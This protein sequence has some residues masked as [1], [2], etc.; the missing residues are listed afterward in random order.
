MGFKDAVIN[1][2][3]KHYTVSKHY[4]IHTVKRNTMN[5]TFAT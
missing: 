3:L 5:C 4:F 2:H 1:L